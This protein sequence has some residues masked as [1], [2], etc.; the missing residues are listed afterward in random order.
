[1]T[2]KRGG[3]AWAQGEAWVA[4]DYAEVPLGCVCGC[5]RLRFLFFF[6]GQVSCT[7]CW[8]L[9]GK[10]SDAAP[11][12]LSPG[13]PPALSLQVF[14]RDPSCAPYLQGLMNHLFQQTA[15]LLQTP[16]VCQLRPGMAEGQCTPR[17]PLPLASGS[18][19]G[20]TC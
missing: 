14:G 10:E 12:L 1:V 5:L 16:K 2:H 18:S 17:G 3:L 8:C 20:E 4:L 15:V 13:F 11:C 6:L 7:P 9:N 19:L